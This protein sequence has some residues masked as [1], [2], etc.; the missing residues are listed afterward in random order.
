MVC[1]LSIFDELDFYGK[2]PEFYLKGKPQIKT[3]IGRVLTIIYIIIYIAY[4][5]YKLIR[6]FLRADLEF[7]DSNSEGSETLILQLTNENFYFTFT[8]INALTGEPFLDETI[9]YLVASFNEEEIIEVKPCTLDKIGSNYKHLF[10]KDPY[11]ENYFCL[12]KMDYSVIAYQDYFYISIYPCTN[13]SENN[14]HC[15]PKEVIDEN[16]NGASIL[17][18]MEDILVTPRNY[19]YPIRHR[20]SEIYSYAFKNVGQY[21]Y[22]EF[23]L[24]NIETNT[25]MI[26]LDFLQE[27]KSES[28]IR[29]DK[30]ST[31]PTPGY[32]LDDEDNYWPICEMEIQIKDTYFSER[33][34]YSQ[35]FDVF[36]EVGG[37]MEL[38][39]SFFGL[40]C[41]FIVDIFYENSITNNLFSFD[42][43]KKLIS[44]KKIDDTFVYKINKKEKKEE[45][46]NDINNNLNNINIADIVNN[47]N[48]EEEKKE[49]KNKELK[50]HSYRKSK[51]KK[52]IMVNKLINES[53][54]NNSEAKLNEQQKIM[55]EENK[56]KEIKRDSF[57]RRNSNKEVSLRNMKRRLSRKFTKENNKTFINYV[58]MNNFF[59]HFGFCCV[60]KKKNMQ[61]ILMD[62]SMNLVTEKLD[63]INIFRTLCLNEEIQYKYEF[64][65]DIIHMSDECINALKD[66]NIT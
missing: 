28:F 51:N 56:K 24:V 55:L 41:S 33:R 62:E 61:N 50:Y 66:I 21:F 23:Q 19:S 11:L 22:I 17:V 29:F 13:S 2:D 47:I 63:I 3:T 39:S 37:F 52:K 40:I 54:N 43:Q 10:D 58:T 48:K 9:Y 26:G 27:D 59:V 18:R 44:I 6:M 7:Y 15:Q 42:L 46:K 25:N 32:N 35:L 36:G 53:S 1:G 31:L 4:F 30:V 20:I 57:K 12:E 14:Y 16:L 34:Q 5:I 65:I 45:N 64:N 49:E 60:R 38:I 8:I